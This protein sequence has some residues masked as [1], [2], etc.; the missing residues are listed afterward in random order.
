MSPTFLCY[1]KN[2]RVSEELRKDIEE[3]A[4]FVYGITSAPLVMDKA[5]LIPPQD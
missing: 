2:P 4:I 5:P 3:Q 1:Y